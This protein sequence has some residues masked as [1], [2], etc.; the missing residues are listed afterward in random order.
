MAKQAIQDA[1]HD[2]VQFRMIDVG[3]NLGECSL[4]VAALFS[5]WGEG[6]ARPLFST[7][8]LAFEPLAET[9][10]AFQRSVTDLS[11]RYSQS[12]ATESRGDFI[13][14]RGVARIQVV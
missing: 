13:L 11:A 7:D 10:A 9:S 4:W 1:A 6:Q 5:A 2:A 12:Q 14:R 8:I 3:A